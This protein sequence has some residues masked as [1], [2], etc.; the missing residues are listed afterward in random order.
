MENK[1][2]IEDYNSNWAKEFEE[3]KGKLNE[4]LNDN[5]ILLNT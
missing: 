2:L 1:I 5:V 4:I 3:E